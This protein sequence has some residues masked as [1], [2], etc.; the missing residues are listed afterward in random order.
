M[1]TALDRGLRY[2]ATTE[3]YDMDYYRRGIDVPMLDVEGYIEEHSRLK[4]ALFAGTTYYARGIEL[5]YDSIA[6]KDYEEL[7]EKYPFDVVINSVHLV[8]GEDVYQETY[9]TGREK[10]DYYRDYFRAVRDSLEAPYGYDVVGHIGYVMR[11][12]PD[13][14]LDDESIEAIRDILK[15]IIE[16]GK[17][18]EINSHV[19]KTGLGS[20]PTREMLSLYKE[21]GGEYV[22]FSSDAHASNRIC[23]RYDEISA[24]AK[25]LGYRYYAIYKDRK[26]EMIKID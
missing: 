1:T 19:K 26:R 13:K 22:T 23:D 11:Y 18:L 4:R 14:T 10:K 24:M 25:D 12:A 7:I 16:L 17:T 8:K 2:L 9:Y 21:L 15:R 20:V 5:G 3:H 6:D